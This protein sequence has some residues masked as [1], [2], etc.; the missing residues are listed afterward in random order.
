MM[1]NGR[2]SVLVYSTI[3]R[4]GRHD[5]NAPQDNQIHFVSMDT[6]CVCYIKGATSNEHIIFFPSNPAIP[7]SKQFHSSIEITFTHKIIF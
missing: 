7:L 5:V 6:G 1:I 4:P 2:L 3:G